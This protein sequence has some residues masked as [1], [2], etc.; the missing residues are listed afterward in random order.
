MAQL[1]TV[2]QREILIR[3]HWNVIVKSAHVVTLKW[4]RPQH[5][6]KMV[7]C[8]PLFLPL[9]LLPVESTAITQVRLIFCDSGLFSEH[10]WKMTV[11]LTVLISIQEDIRSGFLI[12]HDCIQ[13]IFFSY[14]YVGRVSHRLVHLELWA[15]SIYL[16]V[17]PYI[18][19]AWLHY[20]NL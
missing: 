16:S 9:L 14:I 18:V 11:A 13:I 2:T 17:C 12:L 8:I 4:N 1:C 3:S 10:G 19:L 7:Y 20:D 5:S 6:S 15:I